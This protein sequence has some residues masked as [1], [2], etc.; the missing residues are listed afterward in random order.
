M[1]YFFIEVSDYDLQTIVAYFERLMETK[2]LHLVGD[3]ATT[4]ICRD[5]SASRLKVRDMYHIIANYKTL[6]LFCPKICGGFSA[7]CPLPQ[8]VAA[9]Y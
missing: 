1:L 9:P 3:N 6:V 2:S 5:G 4:I 8:V 7:N